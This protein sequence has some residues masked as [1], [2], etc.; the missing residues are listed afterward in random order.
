MYIGWTFDDIKDI[1]TIQSFTERIAFSGSAETL[2][3][4]GFYSRVAR[5]FPR[6]LPPPPEVWE[7][8]VPSRLRIIEQYENKNSPEPRFSL[9]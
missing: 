8:H 6:E 1:H 5:G 2:S 4:E 7:G 3:R 9:M